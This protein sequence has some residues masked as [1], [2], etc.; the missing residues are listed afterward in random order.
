M[1]KNSSPIPKANLKAVNKIVQLG[2]KLPFGYYFASTCIRLAYLFFGIKSKKTSISGLKMSFLEAGKGPYLI[3]LH[4]LGGSSLTW[5]FN[6]K[7]LSKKFHI[8]APD[9]IGFGRSDKPLINYRISIMS[10]YLHE[11]LS[12]RNISKVT[13]LG[14]S[15]GG[16][17]ATHFTLTYPD[18]VE[19][20][21]LVDSA[22]YALEHSFS[23]RERSLLNAVT[24]YS[25]K[26]FF[27]NLFF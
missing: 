3:L 25:T 9:Q 12:A 14:S 1:K 11:F 4:G 10:E 13:L 26:T 6:I 16:W 15:L 18:M 22:G 7:Y 5:S 17:I 21:I 2:C 24:L 27:Q 20:L 19:K 8:V 23:F